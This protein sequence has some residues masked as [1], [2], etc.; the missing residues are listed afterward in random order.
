LHPPPTCTLP[1]W[2]LSRVTHPARRYAPAAP[3]RHDGAQ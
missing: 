3:E 1:L 2:A